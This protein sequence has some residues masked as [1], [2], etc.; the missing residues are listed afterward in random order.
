VTDRVKIRELVVDLVFQG[1]ESRITQFNQALQAFKML[2]GMAENAVRLLSDAVVGTSLKVAKAGDQI[3]KASKQVGLSIPVYEAWSAAVQFS[4]GTVAELEIGVRTLTRNLQIFAATGKGEGAAAF[5][6]FLGPGARE[7]ANGIKDI[8]DVLPL[9]ADGYVALED[10]IER[11]AFVQ[12]VFGR[13]GSKLVPLLEAGSEGLTGFRYRMQSVRERSRRRWPNQVSFFRTI[14]SGSVSAGEG[15]ESSWERKPF[16]PSWTSL[17]SWSWRSTRLGICSARRSVQEPSS[18]RIGSETSATQFQFFRE[19]ILLSEKAVAQMETAMIF[20]GSVLTLITISAIWSNIYAL[21]RLTQAAIVWGIESTIAGGKALLAWAKAAAPLILLASL[22]T[23]I[24]LLI[25]DMVVGVQGGESVFRKWTDSMINAGGASQV[26]GESLKW[27]FQGGLGNDLYD[28]GEW[29]SGWLDEF[30]T[31]LKLL[32]DEMRDAFVDLFD[33]LTGR[34]SAVGG[35]LRELFELPD[36]ITGLNPFSSP[37]TSAGIQRGG[38]RVVSVGGST[39]N[40]SVSGVGDPRAVGA[41][42]ARAVGAEMDRQATRL[43]RDLGPAL[44]Y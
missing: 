17:M 33:W 37:A 44:E 28:L 24:V 21:E 1:Q 5:R 8:A 41:E 16:P 12:R 34:L 2:A 25:E 11:A 6:A 30:G 10:P 19:E 40:V 13:S 9:L 32:P 15:S 27:L 20:L 36:W 18:S 43:A 26:L 3:A 4:G 39:T 7:V 38:D 31:A 42:A 14:S 23:A 22:I 35:Y 29:F